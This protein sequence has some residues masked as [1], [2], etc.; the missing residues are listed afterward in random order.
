[1]NMKKN[2]IA[3]FMVLF[4]FT[5]F[6]STAQASYSRY[7][8]CYVKISGMTQCQYLPANYRISGVK[9]PYCNRANRC[10]YGKVNL[11]LSRRI[12]RCLSRYINTD[13]MAPMAYARIYAKARY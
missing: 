12:I 8:I 4:A 5:S 1:M 3:F 11:R 6:T 10:R 2:I 13:E 7:T 9:K